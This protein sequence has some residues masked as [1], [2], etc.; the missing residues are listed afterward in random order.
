MPKLCLNYVPLCAC[1]LWRHWSDKEKDVLGCFWIRN[2]NIS[3]AYRWRSFSSSWWSYSLNLSS[4]SR[5]TLGSYSRLCSNIYARQCSNSYRAHY[6]TISTG[7]RYW[8]NRLASVFPRFEPYWEPLG[9]IRCTGYFLTFQE[10]PTEE[11][12]DYL[13]QCAIHTWDT[14]DFA[15]LNRLIDTMEHRVAA[16][17][18]AKGWYTKY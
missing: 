4:S 7:S 10:C 5:L 11:T 1:P 12:L 6:F 8:R 13:I 17:L 9:L 2:T 16:V 18:D 15:I 14:L 3:C